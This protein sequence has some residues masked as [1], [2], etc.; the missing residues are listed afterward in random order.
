MTA[1]RY[2]PSRKHRHRS[3][4]S[5]RA[6][7]AA[8]VLLG[9]AVATTAAFTA[10]GLLTQTVIVPTWRSMAPAVFLTNFRTYG[11]I[12]GATLFPI[13]VA[14]TVLL[15]PATYT[16]GAGRRRGTLALATAS[17]TGTILLLPIHFARANRKLLNPDCPPQAVPAELAAW[18][19]WNWARTGL[20]VLATG[21]SCAALR[22]DR[23]R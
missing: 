4:T 15:A 9:A 13:E 6:D 23:A 21:L 5:A 17:M 3:D 10:G 11:P 7:E 22:P 20:A 2:S 12:T 1:T 18:S 19:A 8:G 16:A 14:S